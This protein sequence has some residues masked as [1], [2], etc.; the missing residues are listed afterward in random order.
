MKRLATLAT[1]IV[2]FSAST[3]H[4]SYFHVADGRARIEADLQRT[5]ASG[6][7]RAGTTLNCDHAGRYIVWCATMQLDLLVDGERWDAN[8]V[9]STRATGPVLIGV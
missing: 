8:L 1:L 6:D 7:S 9:M 4:A 2:A 3:A 5:V